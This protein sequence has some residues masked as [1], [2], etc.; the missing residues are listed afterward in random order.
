MAREEG[1]EEDRGSQLVIHDMTSKPSLTLPLYLPGSPPLSQNV[2]FL[3][4]MKRN[5]KT[6][7]NLRLKTLRIVD[8]FWPQDRQLSIALMKTRLEW[9]PSA[10]RRTVFPY[11]PRSFGSRETH[12]PFLFIAKVNEVCL[13]ALLPG[14]GRARSLSFTSKVSIA[15]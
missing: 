2:T 14:T 1:S 8:W 7:R 6:E 12:F 13:S 11:L 4:Q 3:R 5:K 15:V 9:K 10:A